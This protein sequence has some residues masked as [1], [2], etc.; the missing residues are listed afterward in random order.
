MRLFSSRQAPLR[1]VEI[2]R[3]SFPGMHDISRFTKD[4]EAR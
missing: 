4:D 2:F 3:M 1:R